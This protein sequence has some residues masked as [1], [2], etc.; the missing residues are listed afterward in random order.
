MSEAPINPSAVTE[1]QLGA[2]DFAGFEDYW[3]TDETVNVYLPDGK[4]FFV[5]QPMNEGAKAKFQKLT[6][7]SILLKQGSGD[8]AIDVDPAGERHTLIKNSVVNWHLFQRV[9]GEWVPQPFSTRA[10]DMWLDKAPPKAVEHIEHQ[11]RL[12]N[13]WLQAEMTVEEIDKE[14]ERLYDLRKQVA[15]REQGEGS[16]AGK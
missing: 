4:Q 1:P 10:L 2:D 8:A 6:S 7:K 9:D 13:P 14:L 11:I 3:G 12:V 16:S 15:E 5:V